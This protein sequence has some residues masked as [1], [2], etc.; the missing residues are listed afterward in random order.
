M[1]QQG[2]RYRGSWTTHMIRRGFD[3]T[4]DQLRDLIQD[5]HLSFLLGAGASMPFFALLGDI[6]NLLTGIDAADK[7]ETTKRNARASVY[8]AF[9]QNVIVKNVELLSRST[10]AEPVVATYELFLQTLGRLLLRRRSAVINKQVNLFTTNVDLSLEVAAESLLLELNDGFAGRFEPKFNSSNFGSVVSRR[11]LQ[12]DNLSEIPTFNLLKLHGSVCWRMREINTGDG[13]IR[14]EIGFDGSLSQ[15]TQVNTALEPIAPKIT[16]VTR[17]TTLDQLLEAA[18]SIDTDVSTFIDLY[19]ALSIVNPT[20]TKFQQ[21]VLNAN[22]YDLL[23]L[24]ANELEK[25]NTVLFVLGFSCRDEHIRE[26]M[27]RAARV[28]PTLQVIVFAYNADSADGIQH[29]FD[30]QP[31]TNGNIRIVEPAPTRPGEREVIYDLAT[32]TEDFFEPIVPRPPRPAAAQVDVNVALQPPLA[33][34]DA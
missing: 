29:E 8:A 14:T 2:V 1:R 17:V 7:P 34:T 26:L 9:F 11:S 4:T 33:S 21:T 27:V 32:I 10:D 31:I 15:V 18:G 3:L 28:N 13:A 19:S 23:R 25:E 20:K 5:A 22:Y 6:E 16:E 12:Y 24:F 30:G